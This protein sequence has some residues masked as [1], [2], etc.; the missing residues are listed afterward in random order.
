VAGGRV[1]SLLL[2]FRDI[3]HELDIKAL[4]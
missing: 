2:S 1:Y 3:I 4:L